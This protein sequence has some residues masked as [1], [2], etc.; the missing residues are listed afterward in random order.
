[1]TQSINN[2]YTVKSLYVDTGSDGF[3]W[4]HCSVE[5]CRGMENRAAGTGKCHVHT[6]T[7]I[8]HKIA[9]AWRK[10]VWRLLHG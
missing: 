9:R 7:G 2:P 1:M 8:H 4:K 5:G 3:W 10:L 6:Y